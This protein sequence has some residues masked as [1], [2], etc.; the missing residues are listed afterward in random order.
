MRVAWLATTALSL[1]LNTATASADLTSGLIAYYPFDGNALDASGNG[2]HG[3]PNAN[4]G[5]TTGHAGAANSAYLFNGINS[6]ITIPSSVSLESPTNQI[7]MAAW[8]L[9]YGNSRVG[10]AFWPLLMKSNSSENA[11]MYRMSGDLYGFGAAFNT[12][13]TQGGS[14]YAFALN[15]WTF[16]AVTYDGANERQYVNGVLNGTQARAITMV[17]DTRPLVI[18][19]DMPG[20]YES[21]WGKIDDVRIYNR[22]LSAAEIGQL[23]N[24]T[25]AVPITPGVRGV[26]LGAPTPNPARGASAVEFALSGAG[27]V[28]LT[29]CDALGRRV[30]TLASG[31]MPAG[32][33]SARWDGRDE[34]GRA[35]PPGL[36]FWCLRTPSGQLTRHS[37]QLR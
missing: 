19:G 11:F 8:I 30:R 20:I 16:V 36:Y 26:A 33:H 23:A 34:A 25:T 27:P 1:A 15:T 5:L 35:A 14:A 3:I 18:G 17:A 29:V 31:P 13:G 37:I 12:W 4:T 9:L 10:A 22:A 7:T 32:S 24:Q 6:Q 28:D 2:N 21:F